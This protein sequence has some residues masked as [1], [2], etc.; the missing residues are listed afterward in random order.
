MSANSVS[1]F[2][3]EKSDG[4]GKLDNLQT[5]PPFP[6]GFLYFQSMYLQCVFTSERKYNELKYSSVKGYKMKKTP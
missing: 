4:M 6:K 2:Y 3:G 1:G 5:I